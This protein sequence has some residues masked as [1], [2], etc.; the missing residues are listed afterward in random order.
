MC[1]WL[2]E[3]LETFVRPFLRTIPNPDPKDHWVVAFKATHIKALV[4]VWAEAKKRSKGRQILLAGR[5]VYLFEVLARLEG[6]PTIF[7]PDISR[8]TAKHVKENYK[9]CYLLDTGFQGSV[10]KA[11]GMEHYDLIS[12]SGGDKE[13]H[14]VFPN[15]SGEPYYSLSS[16]LEG[17]CK[18]WSPG[19]YVNEIILQGPSHPSEFNRA[20]ILTIHVVRSVLNE[21]RHEHTHT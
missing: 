16:H 20:A 18:Y 7:R 10:P 19:Q 4:N 15:S 13:L 21:F 2:D 11:L 14:Q 8:D 17:V 9:E 12:F 5:D 1:D 3:H 6:Y